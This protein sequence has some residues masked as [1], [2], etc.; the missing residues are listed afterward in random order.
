MCT[1]GVQEIRGQMLPFPRFWLAGVELAHNHTQRILYA[2]W[3]FDTIDF[4]H[5]QT[6][7]VMVTLGRHTRPNIIQRHVDVA[8][9][10]SDY[11]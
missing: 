9:F 11:W 1:R 2:Q 3:K 10:Q 7:V 4:K 5:D 8:L 6:S